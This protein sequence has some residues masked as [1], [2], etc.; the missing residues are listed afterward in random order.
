MVAIIGWGVARYSALTEGR[1]IQKDFLYSLSL[2]GFVLLIY[3][4]IAWILIDTYKAPMVILAVFPALAVITHSSMTA[5][6]RLR[7]RIVYTP[8]THQL[9]FQLRKLSRQV[10]VTAPLELLLEPS[11]ETLCDLCGCYLWADHCL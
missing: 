11:L 10:G 9:R 7:D 1:T 8:E 4:P 2:L 3:I 6:D 5:I